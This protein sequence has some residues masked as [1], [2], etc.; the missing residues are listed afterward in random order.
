MDLI[1]IW[2]HEAQRVFGDRMINNTDK[3]I[4]VDLL[5]TEAGKFK[6]KKVDIFNS[7]RI[8]FGD[9]M[10]GIDGDNRPYVQVKEIEKMI[11]RI[12]EYLDDYNS[13]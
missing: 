11:E 8:L 13:V 9:Y 3:D 6:L 4:L 12:T 1:R 10:F 5:L 7:D 2:I